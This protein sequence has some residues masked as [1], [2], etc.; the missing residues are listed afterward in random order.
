M[1]KHQQQLS[2]KLAAQILQ[3]NNLIANRR[4]SVFGSDLIQAQEHQ[5][6]RRNKRIYREDDYVIDMPVGETSE[7]FFLVTNDDIGKYR[8]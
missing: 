2:N 5:Q 6:L 4:N 8:I 7:H 1:Q 3:Q